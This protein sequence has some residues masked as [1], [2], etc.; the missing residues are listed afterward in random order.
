MQIRVVP[1]GRPIGRENGGGGDGAVDW[2]E[3]TPTVVSL[4][5]RMPVSC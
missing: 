1:V 5:T 3:M 4:C 2:F